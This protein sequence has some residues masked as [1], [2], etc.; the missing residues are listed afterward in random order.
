MSK[1]LSSATLGDRESVDSLKGSITYFAQI[2]TEV[3]DF[4]QLTNSMLMV[5]AISIEHPGRCINAESISTRHIEEAFKSIS[6]RGKIV[7]DTNPSITYAI[8]ELQTMEIV[9]SQVLAGLEINVDEQDISN[10]HTN[11]ERCRQIIQ[12]I[13][14]RTLCGECARANQEMLYGAVSTNS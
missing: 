1:T 13:R 7:T 3:N 9:N 12:K 11:Q 8:R 6:I 5:I 10:E 14:D 4:K 2:Q